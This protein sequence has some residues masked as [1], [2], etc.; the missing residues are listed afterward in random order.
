MRQ[1][2]CSWLLLSLLVCPALAHADWYSD[3]QNKMGTRVQIEIWHE[4]ADAAAAL[5]DTGMRE[6]DR[7]EQSMSTYIAESE[8]SRINDTAADGPVA[9]GS[10]LF[11][12][13][14]RA[15]ELS[16]LT[17]GAFDITYDSVGQLYDYRENRRPEAAAIEEALPA[18]D[19]RL[20]ELDSEA[21]TIRFSR[22][23]VRINLG[24]IAKGYACESVVNVLRDNGVTNAL[25][26]AGGDTRLLGDRGNGPWIVGVRDPEDETGVVTRLAAVDEA[27]ST[28]GD[29]ERFFIA[30]GVRYHH[31]LSPA[32]GK[33]IDGVRSVTVVGPDATMT[34]GLS[35]SVFVL[36]PE[37]GLDLIEKL[38]DYEAIVIDS[39]RG[40]RLSRGFQAR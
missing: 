24:G 13:I 8:I 2:L 37:G 4:D 11:A 26:N 6:F 40:I 29:Y 14:S 12:L 9:V 3:T 17:G 7:I 16:E 5:I 35:T 10:E 36:G 32:T 1:L 15:L 22:P 18:L 33:S 23:G 20:V 31:I 28:S 30:D 27:V 25:V 38:P 19:Y 39:E 21:S 34:D